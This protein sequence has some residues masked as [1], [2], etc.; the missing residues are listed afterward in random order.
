TV[1][2]GGTRAAAALLVASVTEA[3][4]VGALAVR[5]TVP[6]TLVP[7]V[8]P[9]TLSVTACRAGG[10][11]GSGPRVMNADF[12]TPPALASRRTGTPGLTGLVV[13]AKLFALFPGSMETVGGTWTEGSLLVSATTPPPAGAGITRPTVPRMAVP[14]ITPIHIKLSLSSWTGCLQ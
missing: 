11:F 14:P 8:T 10:A 6:G 13:M 5:N 2:L 1:T 7:P 9:L 3:P 4:P 12:V